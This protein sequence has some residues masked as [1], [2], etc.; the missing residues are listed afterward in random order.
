MTW[1][2]SNLQD[3]GTLLQWQTE[4]AGTNKN[5]EY[6][7]RFALLRMIGHGH[8]VPIDSA[9]V[10]ITWPA[11]PDTRGPLE[12]STEAQ[13]GKAPYEIRFLM[14]SEAGQGVLE[15]LPLRGLKLPRRVFLV[16]NGGAAVDVPS[17]AAR[18]AKRG[19]V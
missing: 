13:S 4:K 16:G 15:L 8:I 2:A 1:P 9:T 18:N 12:E 7:G 14:R 19:G 3:P 5:Y 11:V 17:P 10:Q 6:G